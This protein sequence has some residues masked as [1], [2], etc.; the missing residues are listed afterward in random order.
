MRAHI[1]SHR[2]TG[3]I[4]VNFRAP[5]GTDSQHVILRGI[6]L[7]MSPANDLEYVLLSPEEEGFEFVGNI[8]LGN[9]FD[10]VVQQV[11]EILRHSDEAQF[12]ID[13]ADSVAT[14]HRQLNPQ[15][16]Q[17]ATP[18]DELIPSGLIDIEITLKAANGVPVEVFIPG[19]PDGLRTAVVSLPEVSGVRRVHDSGNVQVVWDPKSYELKVRLAGIAPDEKRLWVRIA[20]GESGDL[21]AV[22]RARVQSDGSAVSSSVVP[23]KGE[24]GELYVDVTD[25]P[26]DVIGSSR[27]R[28]RQRAARLEALAVDLEKGGLTEQSSAA[29]DKAQ[30]LRASLGED[31][32]VISLTRNKEK[33]SI[34]WVGLVLVAVV[35]ALFGWLVRGGDGSTAPNVPGVASSIADIASTVTSIPVDSSVVSPNDQSLLVYRP[36]ATRFFGQGNANI[37]AVLQGVAD[38]MA[39]V[40]VQIYDQYERSLGESTA[41]NEQSLMDSC[42]SRVGSDTGSGGGSYALQVHVAAY[43]SDSLEDATT[44]LTSPEIGVPQGEFVGAVTMTANIIESCEVRRVINQDSV[45][46]VSRSAFE[47]FVMELPINSSGDSYVVFRI[48]NDKGSS[49]PWT[50]TEVLKIPK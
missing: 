4:E 50:S 35:G 8:V 19:T 47:S 21:L 7:W 42:Q 31:A 48:I 5:N 23:H 3:F 29:R 32:G 12:D 20:L 45:V 34:W 41:S 43:I 6:H 36:G 30:A 1:S 18:S 11:N 14:Q 22:D 2:T 16:V 37:A 24:L 39:T 13:V 28:V 38:K 49:S 17:L 9:S 26:T 40:E 44:L 27:F 10:N 15:S 46:E 33:R 25:S